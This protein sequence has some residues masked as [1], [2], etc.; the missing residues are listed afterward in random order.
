MIYKDE[1]I[2]VIADD[3]PV[4]GSPWYMAHDI[5]RM[6]IDALELTDEQKALR[7]ASGIGVQLLRNAGFMEPPK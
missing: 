2:D 4:I 6:V 7:A 1:T 3:L 5:V